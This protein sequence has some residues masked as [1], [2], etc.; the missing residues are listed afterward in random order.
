[1]PRRRGAGLACAAA[2]ALLALQGCST[3]VRLAPAEYTDAPNRKGTAMIH[4]RDGRVYELPDVAVDSSRFVGRVDVMR[5][6]VTRDGHLD[7]VEDVETV[8]IPF[9]D[10]VRVE[11]R[12]ANLLGTVAALGVGVGLVY[13]LA[14]ALGPASTDTTG[15]T[16]PN[17]LPTGWHRR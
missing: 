14:K 17:P 16:P 6:I 13:M 9:S 4:T 2:M 8:R 12:R 10:V 5:N 3:L 1:M 11:M 7:A 15:T